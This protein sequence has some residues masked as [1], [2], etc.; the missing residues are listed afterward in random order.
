MKKLIVIAVVVMGLGLTGCDKKP[1][2]APTPTQTMSLEECAKAEFEKIKKEEGVDYL[3]DH[4]QD[5]NTRVYLV[6]KK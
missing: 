3:V 5:A 4:A 1:E 6:C 2:P